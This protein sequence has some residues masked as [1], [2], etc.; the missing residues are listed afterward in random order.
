M[1]EGRNLSCIEA[2]GEPGGLRFGGGAGDGGI[3]G[4]LGAFGVCG[5]V[6]AREESSEE[7]G[8]AK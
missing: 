2:P 6:A 7:A 8:E 3:A 4:E 5:G 1:P